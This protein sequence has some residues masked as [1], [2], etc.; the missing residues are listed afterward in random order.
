MRIKIIEKEKIYKRWLNEFV[1]LLKITNDI[2]ILQQQS[3]P[4]FPTGGIIMENTEKGKIV[5]VKEK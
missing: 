3:P 4:R 2:I 1:K 5:K